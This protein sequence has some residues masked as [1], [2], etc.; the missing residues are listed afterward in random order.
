MMSMR[1]FPISSGRRLRVGWFWPLVLLAL[2]NCAFPVGGLPPDI[3]FDPGSNPGDIIM[4]DIRVPETVPNCAADLSIQ[5]MS[6]AAVNLNQGPGPS[7]ALDF[8]SDALNACQQSPRVVKFQGPYPDGLSVCINCD[9]QIGSGKPFESADAAC[10]AKCI[11]LVN[12]MDPI[13]AD[14]GPSD[15][16]NAPGNAQVSTN[17]GAVFGS[18][19]KGACNNPA[20]VD[21]RRDPEGVK[22]TF[23]SA[24][25]GAIDSTLMGSGTAA[26]YA[27]GAASDPGQ[28][29]TEGDGWIQFSAGEASVGHA[30]GVSSGTSD[31][32]SSLID[33]D[34][35]VLLD[36]DNFVY[37]S[38]NKVPQNGGQ[39]G[40]NLP[41]QAFATYT[42]GQLFRI[43]VFDK[44][45]TTAKISLTSL[46]A[47][48]VTGLPCKT[49]TTL[50]T[51][52]ATFPAYPLRVDAS[53]KGQASLA[54]VKLMRIRLN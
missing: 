30:I 37:I 17:F 22:W 26:T 20:F 27:E 45:D 49:E 2:P 9:Q 32:E 13:P 7:T 11:D 14:I 33:M 44:H 43:H 19:A 40:V 50:Y 47:P 18:C 21:K 10:K 42:P 34:F 4:C 1:D 5:S 24:N 16:C 29:I 51:L 15:F 52:P 48:C 53:L 31:T 39:G 3:Q 8:S 25:A 41:G 38:V 12:Q 35:A 54:D 23:F 36:N 6:A 28:A 46:S